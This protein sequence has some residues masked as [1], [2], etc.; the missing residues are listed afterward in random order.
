MEAPMMSQKIVSTHVNANGA[1]RLPKPVRQ[2]L[3]LGRKDEHIGFVIEG[4]RVLLTKA[5]VV[6]EPTLSEEELMFLARLS[7]RGTGRRVFRTTEGA[8]RHLWNL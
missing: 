7:N 5:T 8:L 6:P 1:L 3:H 2:A 4:S